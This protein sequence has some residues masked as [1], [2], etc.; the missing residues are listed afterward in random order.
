M[1]RLLI[2]AFTWIFLQACTSKEDLPAPGSGSLFPSGNNSLPAAL[3]GKWVRTSRLQTF[4]FKPDEWVA[5]PI[6]TAY[7]KYLQ[8]NA[9]KSYNSNQVNCSIC[10]I[11]LLQDTLYVMHNNGFYKFPLLL[12]NDSLLHL[13]TNIGQPAHSLPN[14]GLFDFVLEEKYKKVK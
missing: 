14:T 5:E 1:V 9:D 8:F 12:L 4:D 11:E 7:Q 13:K 2:I 10:R 6:D 3:T